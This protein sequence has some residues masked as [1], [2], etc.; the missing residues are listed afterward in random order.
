MYILKILVLTSTRYIYQKLHK[1]RKFEHSIFY[2]I[3]HLIWIVLIGS[4]HGKRFR[5]FKDKNANYD[6][7]NWNIRKEAKNIFLFVET[8][9]VNFGVE[10]LKIIFLKIFL[11]LTVWLGPILLIN[12]LK[13]KR[14]EKFP[15]F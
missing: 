11:F 14:L 1:F 5:L 12:F 2:N 4:N 15:F 9:M 8:C 10:I 7:I 3:F 13:K 6:E